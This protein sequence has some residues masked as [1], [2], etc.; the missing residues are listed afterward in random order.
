[1]KYTPLYEEHKALGAKFMEFGGFDMPLQYTGIIDEHLTV[2]NNAGIFDVSHMGEIFI[3]GQDALEYCEYLT[4]NKVSNLLPGQSQYTFLLNERAGVI[5][6]LIIYRISENEFMLCVNASNIEKDYDWCLT[7]KKG[8]IR[9]T[10]RSPDIG[11]L[12]VQGPFAKEVMRKIFLSIEGLKRP[13]FSYTDFERKHLMISRTGYTG[14]DGFECFIDKDTVVELWNSIMEAGRPYGIKPIG[15]GA[16]DT[17]R[18]E[19]GYPLYGM[20]LNEDTTPYEA[21]LGWVIKMDKQQFIGKSALMKVIE[22]G[23][24][25]KLEGIVMNGRSI[26]R[27]K[28]YVVFKDKIIGEVTTGTYSPSLSKGIAMAYIDNNVSPSEVGVDIRGI[29]HTGSLIQLPFVKK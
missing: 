24:T 17:L 8:S 4:P 19:M 14:E 5:D 3:A 10:D 12:S 27:H 22:T 23:L 7:N 13:N 20:E 18:A 26:P 15:L 16:R 6:D 11:M 25:K 29:L 2:R 21:N 1:M 9:I 28:N